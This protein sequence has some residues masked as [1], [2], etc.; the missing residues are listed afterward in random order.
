MDPITKADAKRLL[1]L[2]TDVEL[3]KWFADQPTKQA[4]GKWED[5]APLPDG[6]QWE[7]HARR[8]DLFGEV[9]DEL[10]DAAA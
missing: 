9:A 3:S 1:G 5:N 8:P 10:K 7:L 4:V 2:Q 6:R